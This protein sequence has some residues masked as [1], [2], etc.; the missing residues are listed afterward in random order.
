MIEAEVV[1]K[2]AGQ[3]L[4]IPPS[5]TG[6]GPEDLGLVPDGALAIVDQRIFWTG[7][8]ADLDRAVRV[9]PRTQVF[10]VHGRL[11]TPGLVDPHTHLVFAGTREREFVERAAGRP[12]L[13]ILAEG[14]GILSTVKATREASEEEL[15]TL[16]LER[17]GRFLGFGVTTVEAKSGYGLT[18]RDELRLLRV[19]FRAAQRQPVRLVP[20]FL[21]AHAVPA[22]YR[23]RREDYVRLVV[24]EMLPAVAGERLAEFCDVYLERGAFDAEESE[25]ILGRGMA[26]GLRPRLHAGQFHDL[27]GPQLAAR[28]GATTADHLEVVSDEGI[29]AMAEAGVTA[30]LLPGAALSL[31]DRF[32]DARRFAGAGVRVALA[33][34]CNPG[35]SMTENLLLAVTLGVTHHK[36]SPEHAFRAVT[37]H[38]AAA[39]GRSGIVGTLAIGAEADVVVFDATDYRQLAWHF[40]VSHAALVLVG[41]EV[42]WTRAAIRRDRSPDREEGVKR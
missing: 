8:T 22:E 5:S 19:I 14:G 31:A 13:E 11:V 33:T 42:V 10:D 3:L 35:T 17:L 12:Y 26:L 32:P 28:L 40:G 6:G 2:H 39:L 18:T 37:D 27:G 34:D 38:A 25:R 7:P 21:G 1:L 4:T 20:T 36:L 29:A 16:A 9:G 15:L 24:D 23:D 30:T 41:G